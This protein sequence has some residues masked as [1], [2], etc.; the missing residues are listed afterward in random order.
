MIRGVC[1]V[2]VPEVDGSCLLDWLVF[3]EEVD[4]LLALLC[5]DNLSGS[6]LDLQTKVPEP[7]GEFV[8]K[9]LI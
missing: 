4:C 6:S 3:S 8:V 7:F 5:L 2:W 9:I 1:T